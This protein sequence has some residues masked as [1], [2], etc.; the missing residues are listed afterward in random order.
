MNIPFPIPHNESERLEALA[1]FKI[2]DTSPEADFDELTSLASEICQTP[3]ALVSL[4]DEKRQWFKS[5][6]GFSV[7]ETPRELAFCAHTIVNQNEI[8]VVNDARRDARFA[9]N[10]L[11]TGDP[12]VIFYAGVPL[13]TDDGY[14]VGSLCVIDHEPKQLTDRQLRAMRT[15]AKQVL[16]QME[17]RRKIATLQKANEGLL[18]ANTFIQKFATTAAHDIKNPLSSILLTS[19][20]LQMRLKAGDDRT[21]SLVDLTISSSRK[22]MTLVDEMLQYSTAPATLITN[23]QSIELNKLLKNVVELIDIPQ[24]ITVN[25]PRTN[26]LL[27]CSGV[28]LEQIFI[29]LITN[30]VRYNDKAEGVIDIRFSDQG[31]AYQFKVTDN[32]MGIAEKNLVKIF[33]KDVILNV[34]DRFNKKGTGLGLY[35]VKSLVEKLQGNIQATS[36][37]GEGTTFMF[38]IKKGVEVSDTDI[39]AV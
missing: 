18:E 19:Q 12:S 21:K 39:K 27:I 7:S 1:S 14:A 36:R 24:S 29:N 33:E 20:A 32:G 6:H 35:T 10:P 37:I 5:A 11:V 26:H 4:I 16:T 30:A 2:L 15:L 3:I 28:A 17:L 31:D 13:V 25:F 38:S 8:M 23:Q 34:I 9:Q 22:L